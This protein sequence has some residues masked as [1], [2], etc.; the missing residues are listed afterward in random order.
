MVKFQTR[1]T[2]K[3][4]KSRI[5]N[6]IKTLD[7]KYK[8]AKTRTWMVSFETNGNIYLNNGLYTTEDLKNIIKDAEELQKYLNEEI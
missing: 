3:E 5:D 6:K 4:V 1:I 2:R 8:F 7:H